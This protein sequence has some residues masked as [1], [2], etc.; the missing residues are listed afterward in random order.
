MKRTSLFE[1]FE[2]ALSDEDG[3]SLER[4]QD[5]INM[6]GYSAFLRFLDGFKMKVKT[7]G[8]ED[9]EQML[10]LL[11]KARQLFP[12]PRTFSPSWDK[13]WKELE[14]MISFKIRALQ[15]IAPEDRGGEWQIIMDNPYFTQQVV[16]YPC[17]S[18]A[19]AAYLYAYFRP[20]I[21]NNEYIRLQKI[22]NVI[23]ELGQDD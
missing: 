17:L 4:I 15:T 13:V 18:F 14:Q 21:E 1:P 5:E 8:D 22:Q 2:R 23:M 12:E 7:F 10:R 20:Q 11:D 16:C 3:R 19:E 6:E 9:S